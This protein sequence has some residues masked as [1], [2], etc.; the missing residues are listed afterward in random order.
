MISFQIK[1]VN[2]NASDIVDGRPPV[3]LGL[4]WTIILYFQI[5]ENTRQM[6]GGTDSLNPLNSVN[7]SNSRRH[8]SGWKVGARNALLQWCKEII[9]P[10]FG[11]QVDNF[12]ASWR[13]GR[14]FVALISALNPGMN[15]NFL[16]FS[17]C[18]FLKFKL[19][20]CCWCKTIY[21]TRIEI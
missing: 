19:L 2:I 17:A 13:D 9:T 18:I 7:E 10:K 15:E 16:H 11:I 5:E 20:F 1:L 12:G 3:I 14:A 6:Y 8:S 21:L 4:I